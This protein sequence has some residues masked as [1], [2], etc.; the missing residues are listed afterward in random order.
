MREL[1]RFQEVA[2]VDDIVCSIDTPSSDTDGDVINYTIDWQ[3]D[4]VAYAGAVLY[5][6]TV[7]DTIPSAVTS[8]KADYRV[9]GFDDGFPQYAAQPN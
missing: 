4:G 3:L 6:H 1:E 5:T 9:R 8:S 7:G 2:G